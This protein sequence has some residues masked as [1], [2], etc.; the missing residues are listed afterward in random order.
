MDM[1]MAWPTPRDHQPC[2]RDWE[3]ASVAS[4]PEI[5]A[6]HHSVSFELGGAPCAH[7]GHAPLHAMPSVL[8]EL[9]SARGMQDGEALLGTRRRPPSHSLATYSCAFA[10]GAMVIAVVCALVLT[11]LEHPLPWERL[12]EV[13]DLLG[14]NT[15]ADA[16]WLLAAAADGVGARLCL[17][18]IVAA[19][20]RPCAA[21]V[22]VAL[23]L[24]G[25]TPAMGSYL[26]LRL[27]RHGTIALRTGS[28]PLGRAMHLA[29]VS[30]PYR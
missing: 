17:C 14:Q 11:L 9:H 10:M 23:C 16:A 29:P 13:I 3:T 5:A 24:V 2:G 15:S 6:A 27:L 30:S 19:S 4:W 12:R 7:R 25:G 26:L 20:E 28:A 1:D 18:A 8:E 22:W 21:V